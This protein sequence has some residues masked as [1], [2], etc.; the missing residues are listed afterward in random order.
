MS[1]AARYASLIALAVLPGAALSAALDADK[2]HGLAPRSIGPAGMSGRVAA[3]DAVESDPDVVYVGA[4]TGGVWKSI[5]GGLTWK[6][7]FDDQPVAVDRRAR[8]RS[9]AIPTSSGSAPARATRATASRSATASTA[10]STA[11][12]PGSTSGLEK[13]ERIHRI[14]A[15]SRATRTSPG[16]RPWA[17][18][19]ARTPS[20]ASSR[21]TDG[22]KTWRK[23]LYVDERTGAADLAIDPVEPEQALRRDVAVPPLAL[24]LPLRRPGLRPLRARTTAAR[25]GSGSPRRT[26]C[27]KGDLGRIGLAI[28]RS[29]PERRLRPGRG[30]EE[31]PAAL[32]RRRRAPGRRST[33][34][35]RRTRG[36]STSRTSGSIPR[37]P[38]RVYS[39]DYTVRVSNDGGKTFETLVPLGRDPRRPPRAVDRP[40]RPATT[41][42]VGNDGGVGG[43]PRPRRDL[44][45]SSPTC[46]SPS[47]TTWPSTWTR[48]TTSTAACRTTAPGAAR[49]PSGRTAASATTTGRASASATASTRCPIPSDSMPRLL[50]VPGRQPRRAG[51]CAPARSKDIQPAP[52]RR[53]TSCASTGTPASR[54][55]PFEP[56]TIYYGSQFVHQSTDR[57]ETWTTISARPDHQQPR[58]AEAGGDRRPD[59]RRHRRRE[60]HHHHRHRAAARR[61]RGVIWVGTDDGRLHVTRDG[62]KTW[63]SVEKNVP[64]RAGQHLGPAHRRL[65]RT[66]PATAFVVFD[67][68]RRSTGR[69]TSTAPTTTARPG[70]ASR[71]RTCAGYALAIEQDPVDP[72]LLFLGTEFGLWVSLDGG[73]DVDCSGRTAFPTVSVMDLAIHPREHD[74]VIAT[75]GRGAL[76]RRRHPPLRALAAAT[77]AAAPAS[78]RRAPPRSTGRRR[79]TAVSASAPAS[80]AARTDPTARCSLRRQ[81]RRSA[82]AGRREAS[83]SASVAE[84]R[85]GSGRQSADDNA[86]RKAGRGEGTGERARRRTKPRRRSRSGTP[87]A[88]SCARCS[89]NRSAASTGSPGTSPATPYRRTPPAPDAE[90]QPNPSGPE[91]P[92]GVYDVT[93]KLGDLTGTTRVEILQP[94]APRPRPPTGRRE[95][96]IGEVGRLRAATVETIER[97]RR[98]APTSTRLPSAKQAHA[99]ALRL[100][101]IEESELPLAAEAK[102]RRERL[103]AIEEK[104][105]VAARHGRH[106]A[107]HRRLDEAQ[108]RLRLPHFE[109]GSA[110]RR[111]PRISAPGARSARSGARGVERL[112]GRRGR[113]LPEAGRRGEYRSSAGARAGGDQL[114][115]DAGGARSR[116][117]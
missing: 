73:T 46:R 93:V 63:T 79:R 17:R 106:H 9:A 28:S 23:V 2:L 55:D 43:Q 60:L 37:D 113:R 84:R 6:P 32:R 21:P 98:R 95:D 22:G 78:C 29:R 20:A 103:T 67:N 90:P 61:Q 58:V 48:R 57:G 13:T 51:T 71:R 33:R 19:G 92:P 76:H 65:R 91:L 116:A 16:S 85:G 109:L 104:L 82:A 38:N 96:A 111:A 69:P 4:A 105:V 89:S 40:A 24:V 75:H 1:S 56:A 14:V 114:T 34:A 87:Q 5:N 108:L 86:R 102:P 27:P 70:R 7:V 44:T 26:A 117:A 41:C 10:R 110:E 101:S 112:R 52:P 68:H 18:R 80:S 54:I 53:A 15:P 77:R 115:R 66:T 50:H 35:R 59:A 99:E 107:R 25:P 100:R 72:D 45:A 39:L 8:D 42:Y 3:I 81:R 74:L 12:T 11:A 88:R 83:A 30:R 31:R 64:R 97:L 94:V 36:R 62:G 47:S 49:R